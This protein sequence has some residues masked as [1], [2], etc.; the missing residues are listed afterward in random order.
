MKKILFLFL[1]TILGICAFAQPQTN[2]QK[3]STPY[4]YRHIISDSVTGVPYGPIP[5]LRQIGGTERPG[6]LFYRTSDSTLWSWSG[7][8]WKQVD[9]P[10]ALAGGN[11]GLGFRIYSPVN[12]GNYTVFNGYGINWDST[13][14]PNALTAKADTSF[15]ST[16]GNR[17]KGVDS[18]IAMI[19]ARNLDSILGS[20]NVA[21]RKRIYFKGSPDLSF[22]GPNDSSWIGVTTVGLVNWITLEGG[23]DLKRRPVL[24]KG[25]QLKITFANGSTNPVV[26]GYSRLVIDSLPADNYY[27]KA[28]SADTISLLAIRNIGSTN[29]EY[30]TVGRLVIGSGLS[31]TDGVLSSTG[32]GM[33][34]PM[35]TTGDIIYSS[36][37]S[38]PARLAAG[39]NGYVLTLASGL[40]SWAPASGGTGDNFYNSDGFLTGPRRVRGMGYPTV[41][42]S[43]GAFRVRQFSSAGSDSTIFEIN[44]GLDLFTFTSTGDTSM[45]YY[46]D[47]NGGI[48]IW[49]AKASTG[50]QSGWRATLDSLYDLGL[51]KSNDSTT[52]K[53]QLVNPVTG[54]KVFGNWQTPGV[55]TV[56]TY[57]GSGDAKGLSITGTSITAHPA[58][59]TTPGGVSL[60]AQYMGLGTKTFSTSDGTGQAFFQDT[61]G[62]GETSAMLS[63]TAGTAFYY[64]ESGYFGIG[65]ASTPGGFSGGS[66][67][68]VIWP[69]G[70]PNAHFGDLLYTQTDLGGQ[71]N[72]SPSTTSKQGLR[73]FL[74]ASQTGDAFQVLNSSSAVIARFNEVGYLGIGVDPTAKIHIAAGSTTANTAPLKFTSGT[75]LTTAEAGAMEYDGTNFY[76]SPS[77]TRK[78]I[79]VTNDATP[80]NGQILI[81][82]GTDYTVATPTSTDGSLNITTGSG[83]LDISTKTAWQS[84]TSGTSVTWGPTVFNAT[85]ALA[86][87]ATISISSPKDGGVYLLKVTYTSG[88]IILP[89]GSTPVIN[90]G[91]SAVTYL[92]GIYQSS[93]T[94]WK[95][96]SDA[97][98]S[99][100]YTPTITSGANVASTSSPTAHYIRSGNEVTVTMYVSVTPTAGSA[101]CTV[102]ASLPFA[103]NMTAQTDMIGNGSANYAG[104]NE[105]IIVVGDDTNDRAQITTS[106]V[107]ST[108]ARQCF[109]TFKYT[110]K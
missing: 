48:K 56:G 57:S 17:Q 81:G 46:G 104:S 10:G 36:S 106:T 2:Y 82:N 49:M 99:G 75:N 108:N 53:P 85:L 20:G 55:S 59:L 38:T 71:V 12:A 103:S 79:A 27:W 84:L 96:Y 76:L 31:L 21:I 67:N 19:R 70:S 77:T 25:S 93:G 110:V 16:K 8:T 14:N 89:G 97:D 51:N 6:F 47:I 45:N 95:W 65:H 83:T 86:H 72:I 34:N 107:G 91:A 44:H 7:H 1:F 22:V 63:G 64:T 74:N 9:A 61:R 80:S 24:L 39:T 13:A 92:T 66:G 40:P 42:D 30:G 105:T 54:A 102:Y 33:A 11:L 3:V 50:R 35:T 88:S 18:L 52:Y 78:R 29:Q 73:I 101:T 100:T 15:L 60:S 69:A 68:V 37:G 58:T 23:T 4:Q 5:T 41:F 32:T 98:M 90:T 26:S 43:V 28:T 94:S 62:G 87:S 109:L